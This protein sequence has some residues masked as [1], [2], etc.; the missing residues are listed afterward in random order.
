MSRMLVFSAQ[1]YSI[2][3]IKKAAYRFSDVLAI[4][5]VPRLGEIECVLHFLSGSQGE[6]QDEAIIAAFKNEVLDQDLR[7]LISKET[8]AI[9]NAVLAYALSKTELQGP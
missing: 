8:E 7:V 6:G 4:D 9:R 1:V 5:I 3:T 2:E